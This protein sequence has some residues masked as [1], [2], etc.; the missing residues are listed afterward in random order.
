M[1]G[2]LRCC[3]QTTGQSPVFSLSA[4]YRPMQKLW[5]R[6]SQPPTRGKTSMRKA[7]MG[8]VAAVS[9]TLALMAPST[10]HAQPQPGGAP[11]TTDDAVER[12]L[13]AQPGA[14][15]VVYNHGQSCKVTFSEDID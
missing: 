7:V 6:T 3:P 12:I 15:R 4:S 1:R 5:H 9:T 11:T 14:K 10:A 2:G 8:T 13:R